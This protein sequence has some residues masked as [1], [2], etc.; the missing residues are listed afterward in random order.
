MNS[1]RTEEGDGLAQL[2]GPLSSRLRVQLVETLDDVPVTNF[3]VAEVT[4]E[5]GASAGQRDR[6]LGG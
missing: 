1:Q 6:T 5:T 2:S 3:T 4:L